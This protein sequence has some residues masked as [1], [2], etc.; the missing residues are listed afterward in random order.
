[1]LRIKSIRT[2]CCRKTYFLAFRVKVAWVADQGV[3][4]LAELAE[5]CDV[6]LP[7]TQSVSA[8]GANGLA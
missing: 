7:P 8:R 4:T 1:M 6:R 2:K 5:Q 3:K